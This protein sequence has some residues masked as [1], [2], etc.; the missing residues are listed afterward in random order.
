MRV[1]VL[2]SGS[3]GNAVL[4]E[5]RG[6]RVLVDAG[7]HANALE[8]FRQ[9]MLREIGLF[10][11]KVDGQHLEMDRRAH[12]HIPACSTYAMPCPLRRPVA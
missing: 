2:G 3:R 1:W 4:L 5:H 11:V 10:L 8:I 12:A 7:F 6:S 9:H